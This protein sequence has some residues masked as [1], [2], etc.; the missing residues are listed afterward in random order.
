[1][2]AKRRSRVISDCLSCWRSTVACGEGDAYQGVETTPLKSSLLPSN[3]S[4]PANSLRRC[5]EFPYDHVQ[6]IC[7]WVSL[8]TGLMN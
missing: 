7:A 1:M 6:P 4:Y 2:L 8:T 5:E 3:S